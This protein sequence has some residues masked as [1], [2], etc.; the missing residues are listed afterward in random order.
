MNGNDIVFWE[1]QI[2]TL[3]DLVEELKKKLLD[4]KAMD[5]PHSASLS[6]QGRMVC[7]CGD[8]GRT[9]GF[10]EFHIN[11]ELSYF[12]NSEKGNW[13][14]HPGGRRMKAAFDHDR[15]LTKSLMKISNGDCKM[16][17]EQISVHGDE[18]L[19]TTALPGTQQ[20]PAESRAMAIRPITWIVPVILSC[21][22]IIGIQGRVL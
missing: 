13:T 18:M 11:E 19:A 10:W 4:M 8:N 1:R 2:E 5:F 21:L 12:F 22:I 16:W 7:K 3:K 9:S 20:A 15:D 6:L 14:V 17:L